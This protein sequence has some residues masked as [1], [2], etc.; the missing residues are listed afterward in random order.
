MI[1]TYLSG[2]IG[3]QMFEY[4]FGRYLSYENNVSLKLDPYMLI[5]RS[6]NIK[7]YIKYPPRD[8]CLDVFNIEATIASFKEIPFFYRHWFKGDLMVFL[9]QVRR[10]L[11]RNPGKETCFNFDESKMSLGPNIYLEGLWQSQKYFS[12]IED[13]I[14]KDFTFKEKF[15]DNINLL[16]EEIFSCD[17]L[18]IHVRRGDYVGNKHHEVVNEEYYKN[19]IKKIEQFSKIDKIYV[20]SDDT[21]WCRDNLKFGYPTTFVSDE[22]TGKKSEGHLY[23]MSQCKNFIIPNSTFSWWGAWLSKNENKIVIVPKSWFADKNINSDDLI[24]KKWIRI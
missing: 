22:Y 13:I 3:N 18:C 20:F 7:R 4:A 8:Y 21:V 5:D 2:G 1:I 23:L 10:K 24:P 14:R 15:S 11:L 9:E 16:K 12:K 17:S 19:A 6:S